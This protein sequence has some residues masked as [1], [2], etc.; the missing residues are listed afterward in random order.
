MI[1]KNLTNLGLVS[2]LG[3]MDEI[4]R[5]WT[6]DHIVFHAGTQMW[7]ADAMQPPF[8]QSRSV[9]T[10]KQVD[11]L[12]TTGALRWRYQKARYMENAAC[13]ACHAAHYLY[14]PLSSRWENEALQLPTPLMP[15][16]RYLCHIARDA[17]C[18]VAS[19]G[20]AFANILNWHLCRTDYHIPNSC[21]CIFSCFL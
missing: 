8:S 11:A 19:V 17:D 7:F 15:S 10:T 13:S 5:F 14:I 4:A 21:I 18:W 2:Q 12:F 20:L 1:K 6:S 9:R 3:H 16:L